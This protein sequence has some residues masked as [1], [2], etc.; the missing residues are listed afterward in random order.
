MKVVKGRQHVVDKSLCVGPH[1]A[2][3]PNR[4][5]CEAVDVIEIP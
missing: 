3:G 2:G 5:I 1:G 4:L